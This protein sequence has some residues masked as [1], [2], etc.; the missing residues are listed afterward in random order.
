MVAGHR[1]GNLKVLGDGTVGQDLQRVDMEEAGELLG[2]QME[3]VP[4][5]GNNRGRGVGSSPEQMVGDKMGIPTALLL[6][7][8]QVWCL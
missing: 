6:H 7:P 3:G 1:L 5:T 8:F 4:G 2:L